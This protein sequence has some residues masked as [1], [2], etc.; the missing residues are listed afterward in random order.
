MTVESKTVTS[1]S[2]STGTWPCGL[3]AKNSGGFGPQSVFRLHGTTSVSYPSFFSASAMRT[4]ALN[5]LNTPDQ[6]FICG[7]P[8]RRG[9]G[10][11]SP[12]QNLCQMDATDGRTSRAGGV[13]ARNGRMGRR[14]EA[15]DEAAFRTPLGPGPGRWGWYPAPAPHP[16]DRRRANSQAVLPAHREPLAPRGD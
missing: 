2:I 3:T 13:V 9:Y 5:G 12:V 8:P 4:L 7:L 11:S 16:A 14:I 10:E 15:E 6:S 1:P